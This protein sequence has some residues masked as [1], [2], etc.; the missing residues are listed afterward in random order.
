MLHWKILPESPT[1]KSYS[2]E[3]QEQSAFI[4]SQLHLFKCFGIASFL[5]FDTTQYFG[6]VVKVSLTWKEYCIN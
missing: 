1:V 5:T 3:K 6:P 4:F 2:V